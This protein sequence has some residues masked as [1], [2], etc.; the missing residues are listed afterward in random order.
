V[1]FTSVEYFVQGDDVTGLVLHQFPGAGFNQILF[2]TPISSVPHSGLPPDDVWSLT[3]ILPP[4]ATIPALS[5]L[6]DLF[7][8]T[9]DGPILIDPTITTFFA[10]AVPE[11]GSTALFLT[12]GLI[13]LG[14]LRRRYTR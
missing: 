5:H 9:P 7:V 2:A 6:T 10:I 11:Y 14:L 4:K 13:A 12:S 8:D 1:S 3:E